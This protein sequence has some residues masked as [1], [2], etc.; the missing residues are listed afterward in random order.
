[1]AGKALC[2]GELLWDIIDGKPYIG[3]APFNLAGHAAKMGCNTWMLSRV[4]DDDLG[5]D[6]LQK[7][8]EI[9]VHAD[10]LQI[11][12]Q[13]PTGT[14]IVSLDENK[15]PVYEFPDN[16]AYQY[17]EVDDSVIEKIKGQGIDLFYFG[18]LIQ[19]NPVARRSVERILEEC[20][21]PHVF[22]DVNIRFNF[23]DAEV[24][25]NSFSHATIVK[26][27][28]DEVKLVGDKLYGCPD[29]MPLIQSLFADYGIQIILVTKGKDGC[30]VYTRDRQEDINE[31]VSKAVD[32]VG[33]GDSF[34]A[35]FI[36]AYLNGDEVFKAARKGNIL[37]DFV[38]SSHG[39][40]PEY[41]ERLFDR[42]E[43]IR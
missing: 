34:S 6:T 2:Y 42:L 25:K 15:V 35:G 18:T 7:V 39:A 24:L 21:F 30:T 20:T 3:G 14:A 8:E 36:S 38:A 11:D 41:T 13:R 5:R 33:A 19:R 10:F 31:C 28:D 12:S 40:I 26:L 22:L 29:E 16:V 43:A 23:C 9:G 32:T 4:G 17:I 37:S 27:N 1:M